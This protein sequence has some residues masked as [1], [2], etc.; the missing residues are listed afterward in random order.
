[1]LNWP[2][3]KEAGFW[4]CDGIFAITHEFALWFGSYDSAQ[5]ARLGCKISSTI[6]P[7]V[8]RSVFDYVTRRFNASSPGLKSSW[9]WTSAGKPLYER[10]PQHGHWFFFW[11]AL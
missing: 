4:R 11:C 9:G 1:M 3:E 7:G 8:I 2:T 5:V 10:Q 6:L